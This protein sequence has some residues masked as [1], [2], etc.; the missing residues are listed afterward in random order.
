[1]KT[2]LFSRR[3]L[4]FFFHFFFVFTL[5]KFFFSFLFLYTPLS[6]SPLLILVQSTFLSSTSSL[7]QSNMTDL[8]VFFKS[9]PNSEF[10]LSLSQDLQSATFPVDLRFRYSFVGFSSTNTTDPP[11]LAFSPYDR[12]LVNRTLESDNPQELIALVQDFFIFRYAA[13]ET[14]FKW[15]LRASDRML[16]NID[17][18]LPLMKELEQQYN[19]LTEFVVR[20]NCIV[21]GPAF[22]EDHVGVLFSRFAFQK[23]F[24]RAEETLRGFEKLQDRRRCDMR[25]AWL[26][27]ELAFDVGNAQSTAFIGADFSDEEIGFINGDSLFELPD[28]PPILNQEGCRHYIAP[29]KDIVFFHT[30]SRMTFSKQKQ[31]FQAIGQ[32]SPEVHFYMGEF[33]IAFIPK[34]CRK[35]PESLTDKRFVHA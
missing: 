30:A 17:L 8:F 32:L 18:L 22:L 26:L 28:C 6:S 5:T 25:L 11:N 29:I 33:H 1:M 7:Q 35:S 10:A 2:A 23:L 9:S 3:R 21:K 15:I 20:G 24:N 14:D 34:L 27:E 12:D 13:L 4:P 19:P 16:F 31:L